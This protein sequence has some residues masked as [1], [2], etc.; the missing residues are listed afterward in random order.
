[1]TGGDVQ[2]EITILPTRRELANAVAERVARLAMQ[3]ARERGRFVVALSGGSLMAMLGPALAAEP[4]RSE[5][6]WGAWHV[7]WADERWTPL[8]S[9]DSNYRAADQALFRHV[10]IPR[11]QIHHL[12]DQLGVDEA[13]EAYAGVLAKVLEPGVGGLPRFDL[14]LLGIGEDGHI[15]SLFPR[16]PML[17]EARRWVVPVL[18]APK[19]PAARITLTLPVINNARNIVFIAVGANKAAI[20]SEVLGPGRAGSGLPARLV[21]PS[22]GELHWYLDR[23]AGRGLGPAPAP[24]KSPQSGRSLVLSNDPKDGG[25][26]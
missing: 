18:D 20:L 14:I 21:K 25:V 7:F 22:A 10:S 12:D 13:I 9:N 23:A 2:P 24:G 3:A 26:T 6:D 5:I 11:D 15:A 16:H 4:W 19:P 1:M 17:D 8:T